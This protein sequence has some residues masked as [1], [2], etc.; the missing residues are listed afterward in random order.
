MKESPRHALDAAE[1]AVQAAKLA[2]KLID[3]ED[4]N[5]D[6]SPANWDF[7]AHTRELCRAA[8]E[9]CENAADN[10]EKDE[11]Y[12]HRMLMRAAQKAVDAATDLSARTGDA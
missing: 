7:F 9:I 5:P 2:Q 12:F 4:K 3:D 10:L 6:E 11:F 8:Q 1:L